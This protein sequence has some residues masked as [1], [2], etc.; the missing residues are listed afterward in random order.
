MRLIEQK[1]AE[2]IELA[3]KKLERVIKSGMKANAINSLPGDQFLVLYYY[4]PVRVFVG[5][6]EYDAL[7]ELPKSRM[8][9]RSA[10]FSFSH[11][12]DRIE[13]EL[14]AHETFFELS[15]ELVRK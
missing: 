3:N 1:I 10:T 2:T 15:M 4:K 13:I 12:C 9:Y 8:L 6:R 7:M 14:V 5:R 11:Y